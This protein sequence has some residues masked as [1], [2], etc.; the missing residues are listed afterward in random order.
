LEAALPRPRPPQPAD[1]PAN[2]VTRRLAA[3]KS[4]T[5][6][7]AARRLDVCSRTVRRYVADGRLTGYRLGPYL[8]RLDA[9]EVDALLR[10]MPNARRSA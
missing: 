2:R 7:E 9:D 5:I 8:I 4:I 10:P 3:H 1:P 6:D